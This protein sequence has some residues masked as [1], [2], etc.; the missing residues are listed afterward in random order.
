MKAGFPYAIYHLAPLAKPTLFG[1]VYANGQVLSLAKE[2]NRKWKQNGAFQIEMKP[3]CENSKRSRF[4]GS[5]QAC[6]LANM[7]EI[8]ISIGNANPRQYFLFAYVIVASVGDIQL[9][10]TFEPNKAHAGHQ[11]VQT[12]CAK[13]S[14]QRAAQII[15]APF[16]RWEQNQIHDTV[17]IE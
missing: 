6:A 12:A 1:D 16:K 2:C 14:S 13:L 17:S 11:R 9:L 8:C 3:E 15:A 7:C 4:N 10:F 5:S